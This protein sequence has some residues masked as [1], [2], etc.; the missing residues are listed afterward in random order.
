[1]EQNIKLL[2]QLN[3]QSLRNYRPV[4]FW[5]W[6]DRLQPAHL[7]QQVR[8]MKQA[9]M[10]GFFMHAR[11]GLETEYMSEEWFAA[12]KASVEEAKQQDM[13]AWCYDENG[14]PSGFAGGALLEDPANWAHYLRFEVKD[15]FDPEALA[16]YTLHGRTLQRVTEPVAGETAYQCVFDCTNSS[17]TDILNPR[18]VDAFIQETHRRYY[19]RFAEEFGKTIKGF[20]TDEP[21]YFRWDTAYSPMLLTEYPKAYGKDLLDKLAALFIDCDGADGF[22]FRYW[23]LMN[24]LF[25]ENFARRVYRWCE[26]HNCMLTGHAVEEC[27]LTGQMECCAGVMPFYEYEHIP[28]IDWLGRGGSSTEVSP[29]Q[30]SSAAQQLGKKQTITETFG[31]A[32]WDVTPRELKHLADIQ[33]V[34]GVNMMCH[35]LYP[36]SIRGQRKRDYPAFYTDHNPWT[37]ELGKFNEHYTN[38]GYLLAETRE[39]APVLIIHPLHSAYLTFDRRN[40]WNSVCQLNNAFEALVERFGAAAI[41]HHYA[42]E[43]LLEK[44]GSVSGTTITLGQC[45]YHCVVI[46]EMRNLDSS[47]V[48]L[49]RQYLTNGGKLYLAGKA[50]DLIDGEPADLSFLHSNVEFGEI[51]DAYSHFTRLDSAVRATLRYSDEGSF[52]YAVNL[53]MEKAE[54]IGF[55]LPFGGVFRFD[56]MTKACNPV[57]FRKTGKGIALEMTLAP[58]ESA[59]LFRDDTAQS[60]SAAPAPTATLPVCKKMTLAVPAE[61]SLTLDTAALSY[62]GEHFTEPLPI[63]A[64]S[65][66]LLRARENRTVWLRYRFTA[67]YIPEVL[68]LELEGLKDAAL[69]INGTPVELTQPG[70]LDFTFV[71]DNIAPMT[72]IGEN[73]ILLQLYHHQTEHIYDVFNAFYYGNC[74]ATETLINCLSYET[75][76]EAIYLFGQFTVRSTEG[77]RQDV[78]NTRT[79][80]GSFTLCPPVTAVDTCDITTQGFPFFHGSMIL[81]TEVELEET[82]WQLRCDGRMQ[83]V[84]VWVNAQ[85]AGLMLFNQVLDLHPFLQLGK[86]TLR[87]ELVASNRNL[88]GPFHLKG[89]PEPMGVGP[90]VFNM[91]GTWENWTSCRYDPDYAF[92]RFGIDILQ[93]EK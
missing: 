26:A 12:V 19:D 65:D 93:L 44:Y 63:M 3:S 48:A 25:C 64:I 16:V 41:G 80:N 27:N 6:N 49:L 77:Y 17:V 72:R 88:Y 54:T 2:Q 85:Y 22:R 40:S 84:K 21:Q 34:N 38:L 66:K 15:T 61:N 75:N 46:P 58:G 74:Q 5:S 76:I 56:P 32:G 90:D 13:N 86:N 50:P 82:G 92:V 55:T 18:I 79:T 68:T 42:D 71:R 53:S 69:F 4:P 70:K 36:Y 14:W 45:T 33:Y 78:N 11:G 57:G 1:M 51:A 8:D 31:C 28:G 62:D 37:Q 91:Y 10:G 29:R 30:L 83:Y 9:G 20:F 7:Q 43:R 39:E 59:V 89:E 23:R 73:E 60:I 67:D 87:L 47:T 81:E 35:H 24:V 52:F